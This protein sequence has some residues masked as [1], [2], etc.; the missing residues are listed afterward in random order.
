MFEPAVVRTDN[1][2]LKLLLL[3]VKRTTIKQ[4][5]FFAPLRFSSQSDRLRESE[6][7]RRPRQLH[8][9]CQ[10][11][12]SNLLSREPVGVSHGSRDGN[13]D[14]RAAGVSVGC[15][16]GAGDAAG[17][18]VVREPVGAGVTGHAVR[19]LGGGL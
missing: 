3:L 7:Y 15:D 16:C 6:R 17:G 8:P 18:D 13:G 4:R 9:N 14:R 5:H 19:E 11:V 1:N 2:I 12:R 10:R